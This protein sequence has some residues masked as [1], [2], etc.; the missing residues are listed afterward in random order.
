MFPWSDSDTTTPVRPATT[1]PARSTPRRASFAGH[2]PTGR[3]G[4][5]RRDEPCLPAEGDNPGGDVGRLA[6]G[7]HPGTHV[8]IGLLRDWLRCA[9]DDVQIQ[10]TDD[11]KDPATGAISP[12]ATSAARTPDARR[13]EA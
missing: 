9:D 6:A 2:Q 3:I 12:H 11:A 10:V 13:R 5:A 1:G 4:R 7:P 8:R